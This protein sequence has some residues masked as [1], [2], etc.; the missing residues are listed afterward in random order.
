MGQ[1]VA[2]YFNVNKCAVRCAVLSITTKSKPSIFTNTM[3]GENVPRGD[4]HDYLGVTVNTSLSWK[5]HISKVHS[6][7]SRTRDLIKQ[8]LHAAAPQVKKLAYEAL[9][10]PVLE[11]ATCAWSPYTKVDTQIIERIQRAAAGFVSGDYQHYSSIT[12][13]LKRLEWDTLEIRWGL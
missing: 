12:A 13:M 6:K 8:T 4:N 1:D 9:V 10:R 7:A 11:Y 3:N 2:V 5:P